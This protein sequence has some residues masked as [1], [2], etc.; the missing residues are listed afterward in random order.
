MSAYVKI[1]VKLTDEESIKEALKALDL[2]FEEFEI[3]EPLVD[4]RGQ[5]RSQT[6]A[7]IIVRRRHLSRLSNDMGFEKMPDGTWQA[8]VSDYDMPPRSTIWPRIKQEYA[9]AVNTRAARKKGYHVTRVNE[10]D[11]KIKLKVTGYR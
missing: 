11:G 3:A 1:D 2:P 9:A 4:Y 6:R 7:N 10:A 5:R 8:H